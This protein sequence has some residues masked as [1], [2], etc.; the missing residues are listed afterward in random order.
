MPADRLVL[1]PYRNGDGACDVW[2][3]TLTTTDPWAA[4]A[5]FADADPQDRAAIRAACA[6]WDV[7]VV[8]LED[9]PGSRQFVPYLVDT[10][11]P[12]VPGGTR[13]A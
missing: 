12:A 5:A 2:I 10:L 8:L 6:A 9:P 3:D 11:R 1:V 7:A 13:H 4:L